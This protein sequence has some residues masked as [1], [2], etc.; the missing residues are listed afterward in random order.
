[1]KDGLSLTLTGG[2]YELKDANSGYTYVFQGIFPDAFDPT[3]YYPIY[4]PESINPVTGAAPGPIP[5]TLL[6]IKDSLGNSIFMNYD[7][8][9]RLSDITDATGRTVVS[10]VYNQSN[11][12][13][14]ITDC[15]GRVVTYGYSDSGDLISVTDAQGNK[16]QYSYVSHRMVSK[17]DP[18][19]NTYTI[20]YDSNLADK[21]YVSKVTDPEE[22][23]TTFQY[24]LPNKTLYH[25]DYNG[26][27]HK[28]VFNGDGKTVSD[29]IENGNIYEVLR[30]TEYLPDGIEKTTDGAGNI[31]TI[32]RDE[33]NNII[34]KTDGEGNQ[35]NYTY[36]E[37]Q[38]LTETD[39]TGGETSYS[40]DTNGLLIKKTEAVGTPDEVS[41]SYTY[42]QWKELTA[43]TRA[44]E[45]TQ[46][47]Y[48]DSGQ[49]VS[50]TDPLG[51]ITKN[52]YDGMGN[53]TAIVD[54]LGNR[55]E[56]TYDAAGHLLTR[57][58]ALGNVTTYTYDADG[59]MVS[60][61]DAKG[62]TTKYEYDFK[63]H[64][65]KV[66]NP[67]NQGISIAYDGNGNITQT[68]ELGQLNADGSDA[69]P[70]DNL[71]TTM[72]YD[73]Q[74]RRTSVTDATGNTTKYE[75]DYT[76]A[77][78]GCSATS[79][80]APSKITDPL[81]KVTTNSFDKD[82][83]VASTTDRNGNTITYTY[84]AA[85]RLLV[86][87]Y[88]DGT[89][90]AYAYDN[91][92]RVVEASNADS[93]LTFT[94]NA[95]GQIA[96]ATDRMLDK[97]ISYAYDSNGNRTQMTDPDGRITNYTYDK[98]GLM[99]NLTDGSD[100]FEFTNDADGRRTAL[101][102]PNGV[103]ASYD[104]DSLGQ[105]TD[106]VNALNGNP[107]AYNSYTYDA[108]GNRLTNTDMNGTNAY[109]YDVFQRLTDALHPAIPE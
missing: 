107:V 100:I 8:N 6:Y 51:N 48:D 42:N 54:P 108:L 3:R 61:T 18:L 96:S 106:I 90:A 22:H 28:M 16:T 37:K 53:K 21:G 44:D 23:Q 98:R 86:K 35:W 95:Q 92:G 57:K 69:N 101:T 45:T 33:W 85:G 30:N 13:E 103:A 65:T 64:I 11:E 2:N 43:V 60:M 105:V 26:Q 109:S 34:N 38:L 15:F 59:N 39:P 56:M 80:S 12:I 55:T 36:N 14:S 70:S 19:G 97:T 79:A 93:D 75:Y 50:I 32:K 9:G 81:G 104:Y 78:C 89:Y 72:A 17:T 91:L 47:Q 83:R 24:D 5:G 4:G 99:A 1:M 68:T 94:Y 82:N 7:Q 102:Y 49:V 76:N 27:V 77:S 41:T 88:P 74:N 40:Y 10:F 73:A 25:T 20:D 46:Y 84:D 31:T 66:I 71:V 58:D 67:L 62:N 52:E 87:N 29:S 63:G